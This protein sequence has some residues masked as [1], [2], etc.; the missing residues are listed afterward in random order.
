[1]KV[2]KILAG[3]IVS[4]LLLVSSGSLVLAKADTLVI[5][6]DGKIE[7]FVNSNDN[8]LGTST[9]SPNPTQAP[10][11]AAPSTPAP[12]TKTPPPAPTAPPKV[13]VPAHVE[14]TVQINPSTTSNQ[15][16][17]VVITKGT[18][19]PVATPAPF[20]T[21][22]PTPTSTTSSTKTA[23]NQIKTTLA[24]PTPTPG[25]TPTP[26]PT[27]AANQPGAVVKTV[28]QVVEQGANGQPVISIK[29][30]N[31]NNISVNQGLTQATTS[32]QIQIS[33]TTHVI[34][35]VDSSGNSTKVSVL[36]TEAVR[37]ATNQGL[38][39]NSSDTKTTLTQ[40]SGQIVYDVSGNKTGKLLG[41]FS[42]SSPVNV[43]VSAVTGKIVKTT[44]SPL[45]SIFGFLIR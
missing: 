9:S 34:S 42:V 25:P 12:S 32:L 16:I 6:D 11:N 36:P 41:V 1:M 33:S 18:P 43:Q 31:A 30:G 21:T 15:K 27:T 14:S 7:L 35:V 19:A 23:P 20:K 37:G 24:T 39:T 8:V 17:Q 3:I 40:E 13:I 28:D 44:Q 29:P 10:S 2:K 45:L 5:Q 26:V 38:I 4:Q 22:V